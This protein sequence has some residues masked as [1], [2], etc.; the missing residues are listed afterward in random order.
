M[1]TIA[2]LRPY[3]DTQNLKT[4]FVLAFLSLLITFFSDILFKFSYQ[5]TWEIGS[6]VWASV[7]F[8]YFIFFNP[9]SQKTSQKAIAIATLLAATI[10]LLI[11][12]KIAFHKGFIVDTN[13]KYWIEKLL[14]FAPI[15]SIITFSILDYNFYRDYGHLILEEE[16]K[17]PPDTQIL[18]SL[19]RS[20]RKVKQ[21]FVIVDIPSLLSV[22]IFTI[23]SLKLTEIVSEPLVKLFFSGATSLQLIL[24]NI[25]FVFID[26][27][28]ED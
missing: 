5:D 14:V 2:R 4:W 3:I 7:Y 18:S 23:Y 26:C 12:F 16:R 9:N 24:S 27:Y 6:L 28:K 19:Q 11:L 20:Q 21:F 13:L 1:F 10:P 22:F 17:N 25:T 8:I 15:I